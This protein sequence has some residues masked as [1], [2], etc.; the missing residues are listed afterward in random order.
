MMRN[1]EESLL[2]GLEGTDR[3]FSAPEIRQGV[4]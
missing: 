2:E 1:R 3:E 4:S